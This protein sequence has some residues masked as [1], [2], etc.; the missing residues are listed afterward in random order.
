MVQ[1]PHLNLK[2]EVVFPNSMGRRQENSY[3][4]LCYINNTKIFEWQALLFAIAISAQ[5]HEVKN[6]F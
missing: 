4:C 1:Q 3:L 2:V 5:K 6:V